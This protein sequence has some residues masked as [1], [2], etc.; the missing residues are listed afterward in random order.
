MERI[1]ANAGL[2]LDQK[3]FDKL[4][5]GQKLSKTIGVLIHNEQSGLTPEE[6]RLLV[7]R[8]KDGDEQ[9]F[10]SLYDEYS[11]RVFNH[12]FRKVGHFQCAEDLTSETFLKAYRSL[13]KF[14]VRTGVSIKSWFMRIGHN[15]VISHL[16]SK[17]NRSAKS[18]DIQLEDFG[19]LATRELSVEDQAE[20]DSKASRAFELISSLPEAQKRAVWM[21]IVEGREYGEI[22]ALT[23]KR[24]SAV[25]TEVHRGLKKVRFGL[26]SEFAF[27]IPASEDVA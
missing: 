7:L 17:R 10:A 22:V 20:V 3:A 15:E 9:A 25:R 26:L 11:P 1:P 18:L 5:R 16:R 21:K 12:I 14:E 2:L 27:E 19:D 8:A 6:E 4:S 13:H 23:G 24:E